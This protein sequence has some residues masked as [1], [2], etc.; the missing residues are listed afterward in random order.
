ML[1]V[2]IL[3]GLTVLAPFC[4][5]LLPVRFMEEKHQSFGMVYVSGWLTMFALCQLLVIPFIVN[6]KEFSLVSAVYTLLLAALC[7]AA[8]I[9]G[10][11]VFVRS[12]KNT[13]S[14]GDY[15]GM[16]KL[17]WLLVLA[18]IVFQIAASYY[19]QYLDGDDSV[20]TALALGIQNGDGMYLKNP[21]Y[22]YSQ[23]LD[24][25]HAL[26]P[27]PVFIAWLGRLTGIHATVLSHS[28]LGGIFLLLMYVIY[29]QLA[30]Q[31]FPEKRKNIPV[32]L[33]FLNLWYLFGN[34]SLYTVETFAYTRTWQG[35]AMFGNLVVPAMFL[36]IMFAAREE[37]RAGE[38]ALLF[39]L[40]AVAAFT[41]ST[42]IFMFPIFMAL[43]GILLALWK[44]KLVLLFEFGVCCIPSMVYGI[45][46]LF[47]K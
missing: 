36:W 8:I 14:F 46:Y 31:L 1:H 35:K 12:V 10:R 18:L 24:T 15:S 11:G 47:L 21:N 9:A 23:E 42:G 30:K 20:F 28:Y 13:F 32:F 29:G 7:A 26:S 3:L 34:V 44:K 43:A 33:L 39:C 45:L 27:V 38:W 25:R 22:G 41:T 16:E 19:M 37:M 2:M 6:E 17:L 40:S 5:G 4:I